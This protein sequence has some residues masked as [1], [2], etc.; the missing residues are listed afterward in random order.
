M[1]E[2]NQASNSSLRD[3]LWYFQHCFVLIIDLFYKFLLFS[4]LL[5]VVLFYDCDY[6]LFFIFWQG[7]LIICTSHND[8]C[9]NV[10]DWALSWLIVNDLILEFLKFGQIFENFHEIWVKMRCNSYVNVV[11]GD[12][13]HNEENNSD[14]GNFTN[15]TDEISLGRLEPSSFVFSKY[16]SFWTCSYI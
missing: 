15:P 1:K 9:N 4:S 3:W 14:S 7:H 6:N 13:N 5:C 11:V 12:I 10:C 2:I 8:N 16:R